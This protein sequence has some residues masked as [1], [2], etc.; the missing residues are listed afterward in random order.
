MI[1]DVELP[2]GR[3]VWVDAPDVQSA[4]R[5][6]K[7]FL[8][9]SAQ[10][11]A[12]QYSAANPAPGA[13]VGAPMSTPHGN[14]EWWD[15]RYSENPAPANTPQVNAPQTDSLRGLK[16]GTQGTARGLTE[17]V[18]G[19]PEI[20]NAGLNLGIHGINRAAE[21]ATGTRPIPYLGSP[22]EIATRRGTELAQSLGYEPVTP[23]GF[24]E[25]A[26]YE[27]NRMG[28][29][30]A[31]TIASIFAL[32]ARAVGTVAPGVPRTVSET[33]QQP[34]LENTARTTLGDAG[35]AA[36]AGTALAAGHE[37]IPDYVRESWAGPIADF[38]LTLGGGIGG[39]TAT[40]LGI[41]TSQKMLA[42]A[43][44]R[45]G[46]DLEQAPG[47]DKPQTAED[48][49]AA[50]TT[51]QS[52]ASNPRSA[53][54]RISEVFQDL[55][56]YEGKESMPTTGAMSDDIGLAS[57]E[58]GARLA[59]Q[60]P[61]LERDQR[62][63]R[64]AV[65]RLERIA[66][67]SANAEAFPARISDIAAERTAGVQ[68]NV[69]RAQQYVDRAAEVRR[70]HGEE[71]T[72][73][74]G[75]GPGASEALDREIVQESLNPMD[76]ARRSRYNKVENVPIP[77]EPVYQ[78]AQD[79]RAATSGLPKDARSTVLP[80]D[81]VRD[82]ERLGAPIRDDKGNIIGY[83][84][85]PFQTL[86]RMRPIISRDVA[87]ARRSNAPP[88][89]IDNLRTLQDTISQ[90]S[91]DL[92][93]AAEA[94]R[95][96]HEDYAPVWG[97]EAG[98]AYGFRQ[99]VNKDRRSRTESPPSQTAGRFLQPEQPERAAALQ[100]I[101]DSIPDPAQAQ[102]AARQYVMTDLAGK[103][104]VDP[105]SGAVRVDALR[106]WRARADNMLGVV[107]GLRQEI[108]DMIGRA[109][110]GERI[111]S[112]FADELRAAQQEAKLTQDQIN[113]G[114][115]GNVIGADPSHAVASI[116]QSN[117]PSARMDEILKA[118]G[119]WDTQARDGMKAAVRDYLTEKA[120]TSALGKTGDSRNP[121]SFARLDD[122][123]K[124]HEDVLS[125]VFSP[126][127]MN[128][129]RA[130]HKFLA[131]LKNLE[132]NVTSGSNTAEKTGQLATLAEAGLKIKFGMLKGG[133]LSRIFK[134]VLATFPSDDSAVTQVLQQAWFDP[135]L[136]EHLLMRD[137]KT[138]S[139]PWWS[140][141]LIQ[142]IGYEETARD[143]NKRL[144]PR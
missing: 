30:A 17:A 112:R 10:P 99:D 6:G 65:D 75:Q 130:A 52:R 129:L 138:V 108:D 101:F 86:N 50:A 124:K 67:E 4:A 21:T 109:Q 20:V 27:I 131:P 137:V 45:T 110:K 15:P 54:Q 89:R 12:P 123:F 23:E 68:A 8:D 1:I 103:G 48:L 81:R 29:N 84:D 102:A 120:T 31:G 44:R 25:R 116:F 49:D 87:E 72:D 85:V 107:P 105:R 125:K 59:N 77:G 42:G 117:N 28:G 32:P 13:A 106:A 2:G 141:K 34:Y 144:G 100:R 33:L 57:F 128:S 40:Q 70:A 5:A 7:A 11:P 24:K 41:A 64:A 111:G 134:Q 35:A 71:I 63:N 66:P 18:L 98:E 95:F 47:L 36:G 60:Q 79:V 3:V 140:K 19:I 55:A 22:S 119:P 51:L 143:I 92:P 62:V 90:V 78:A 76:A 132:V 61:F 39:G 97:R 118:L 88:E 16:I 83:Q 126:D 56:P 91:E 142:L 133:G 80:A 74:R 58:R 122:I 46:L 115:F 121:V 135:Q 93:Q 113:R 139:S 37:Y 127:E 69:E 26:G 73:Y 96:Y 43:K 53:A 136:A 9:R 14:I 94:N 104:V 114:A 38:L 82:F